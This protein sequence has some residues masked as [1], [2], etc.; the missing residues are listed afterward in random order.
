MTDP[1]IS[2]RLAP[3]L[4]EY[5]QLK[6]EQQ[7]RI[8]FR[9][10]LIYATLAA[11]AGVTYAAVQGDG[12]PYLMLLAAPVCI[13]LGWTYLANDY[14]ISNIGRYV[15][16]H[17][18]PRLGGDGVFGWEIAHCCD[19]R[20][21]TRKRLQLAVDLLTFCGSPVAAAIAYWASGEV[22]GFLVAVSLVE[23]AAVGVLGAQIALYAEL[24]RR[25]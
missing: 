19:P 12:R 11:L 16:D 8:G 25:K 5:E 24:H 21:R 1:A 10:N 17:L 3:L 14:A 6:R 7:Q 13:V 23:M 22:T 15:R 18:A 20:R 9:D 4:A 2:D